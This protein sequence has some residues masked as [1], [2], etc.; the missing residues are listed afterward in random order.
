MSL[1]LILSCSQ[2]ATNAIHTLGTNSLSQY[3]ICETTTGSV[4]GA[5][6]NTGSNATATSLVSTASTVRLVVCSWGAGKANIDIPNKT[7]V[8]ATLANPSSSTGVELSLGGYANTAQGVSTLYA[9]VVIG[10]VVTAA[11]ITAL[12]TYGAQY[13]VVSA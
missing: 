8:T 10:R 12:T 3:L 11:D 7:R 6:V 4:Y 1:A 9:A 13:S 2:A 5:K